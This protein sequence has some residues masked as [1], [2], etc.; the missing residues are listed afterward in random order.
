M[1]VAAA[2]FVL[3]GCTGANDEGSGKDDVEGGLSFERD[4]LPEFQ[5]DCTRCHY[6]SEDPDVDDPDIEGHIPDG[7]L[8]LNDDP[9]G[10]II[11]VPSLQSQ[12][13]VLVEPGDSLYSY[14]WHKVNGSQSIADGSGSSMPLGALWTDEQIQR[15]ADWID[16][17]AQP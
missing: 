13:M 15:L 6:Y 2:L 1:R 3:M 9:L 7:G 4:I 11:G 12:D 8:N 16:Q 14:L 5:R 10:S 17:G